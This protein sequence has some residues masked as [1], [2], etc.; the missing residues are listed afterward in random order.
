MST[1]LNSSASEIYQ[2]GLIQEQQGQIKEALH[3]YERAVTMQTDFA[4]AWNSL[5][6]LLLRNN[7][8]EGAKIA[9]QKAVKHAPDYDGFWRNLGNCQLLQNEHKQ[10]ADSF[11]KAVAL[12]PGSLVNRWSRLR[13]LPIVYFDDNEMDYYWAEYR[14]GLRKLLK[15][16]Q[17]NTLE[18]PN[19]TSCVQDAFHIHYQDR[20]HL[21]VQKLHGELVH[22][23]MQAVH[24][25]YCVRPKMPGLAPGEKIRVGF[26]SSVFCDHTVTKLFRG[27]IEQLDRNDFVTNVYHTGTKGDGVSYELAKACDLYFHFPG[28]GIAAMQKIKTD[29]LH[30]LIYPELGMDADTL[31]LAACRL[32]PVQCIAWGHPLT[33]GL[34]TIQHFLS[35][36][37]ME[38]DVAQE[39]YTEKLVCLPNLSLYMNPID[40]G[41]PTLTRTDFGLDDNQIVYLVSQSLF[42]LLP[43]HDDIYVQIAHKL[44]HA[45]FIFI[46]HNSNQVTQAFRFRLSQAFSKRDLQLKDHVVILPRLS[47]RRFL[48]LNL[49]ADVFLDAIGWSGGMTTL[50]ALACGLVPVTWPGRHMRTRHTYAILKKLGISSTIVSST[51]EYI[52]TAIRLGVDKEWRKDLASLIQENLSSLYKDHTA[53]HT[54]Q[55]FVKTVV[56]S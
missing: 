13:V 49:L 15:D 38:P 39:H 31:K 1:N 32:A 41:H 37:M 28:G 52:D 44:P 40:P 36:E 5:G 17:N 27:W 20:N 56:K 46:A 53:I 48:D 29:H 19:D 50:E 45:R 33:S 54:L 4:D 6:N 3:S 10:A 14:N 11:D 16:F 34:P 25:E 2:Q 35:S 47:H 24:P 18:H 43:R 9:Y 12:A 26:V 21:E 22:A 7:S 42:K 30:V 23:V 8:I 51:E 55:D